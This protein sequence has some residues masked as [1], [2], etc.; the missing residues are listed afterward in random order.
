MQFC[1]ENTVC[2]AANTMRIIDAVQKY[3]E[4]ICNPVR[5]SHHCA[6]ARDLIYR[7]CGAET[8]LPDQN[9]C[10]KRTGGSSCVDPYLLKK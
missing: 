5:F 3:L 7:Y 2:V 6:R 10:V 9:E 8:L 4:Q 1:P